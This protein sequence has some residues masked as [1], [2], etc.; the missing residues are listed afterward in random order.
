MR[1]FCIAGGFSDERGRDGGKEAGE[2]E[3]GEEKAGQEKTGDCGGRVGGDTPPRGHRRHR[4]GPSGLRRLEA[5]R[6]SAESFPVL[7]GRRRGAVQSPAGNPNSGSDARSEVVQRLL[8][9]IVVRFC[10]R[11]LSRGG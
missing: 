8:S 10:K 2:E 5:S 11:H 6:E 9:R 3:N 1:A 4:G 7:C